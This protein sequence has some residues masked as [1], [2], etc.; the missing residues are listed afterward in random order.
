VQVPRNEF[1]ATG[2]DPDI[3]YQSLIHKPTITCSVPARPGCVDQQRREPL[4]P[5]VDGDVINLDT[6]LRQQLLDI[7]V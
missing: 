7:P 6:A 1:P 2:I 3:A 4:H 5:A